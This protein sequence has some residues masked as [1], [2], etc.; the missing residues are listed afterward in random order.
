MLKWK[1]VED[2]LKKLRK[3]LWIEIL[4]ENLINGILI[5]S[6]LG[7]SIV[8]LSHFKSI[9][10]IKQKIFYIFIILL[11][12]MIIKS[13]L[14]N[15]SIEKVAK[16]GD[17]L[18]L[19]QRLIT[20]V[21]LK[22]DK[23]MDGV[24]QIF[25]EDLE[26][27][28]QNF[29]LIKKYKINLH[30][31]KIICSIMIISISFGSYFIPSFSRENALEMEEINKSIKKEIVQIDK[32]KK[33]ITKGLKDEKEKEEI[34]QVF[35]KLKKELKNTYNY[36]KALMEVAK[37]QEK[38]NNITGMK[39]E[40]NLKLGASIFKGTSLQNSELVTALQSGNI[41]DKLFNNNMKISQSDKEKMI[42][43]LNENKDFLNNN[44]IKES[45]QNELMKKETTTKD[46]VKSLKKQNDSFELSSK[47][48]ETKDKLLSKGE[49]KGFENREGNKKSENFSLGGK[50][51]NYKYGEN[52]NI[53]ST[54]N[55]ISG[56]GNS[57]REDNNSVGSSKVG[58]N[59]EVREK[60]NKGTIGKYKEATT[61][62]KSNS[63]SNVNSKV[64]DSGK[65][66]DKSVEEVIGENGSTQTMENRWLDYKKEGM[67]YILKYNI[68]L[69]KE[70]IVIDYFKALKK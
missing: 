60:G 18:G 59:K 57:R 19:K 26:D 39:N 22:E 42:K 45:V 2:V 37:A 8:V 16:A 10:Y 66:F 6:I 50:E 46:L 38:L 48:G 62:K 49:Q 21:E 28:L 61:V 3:K 52:S 41:D 9:V 63:V 36:D 47:L 13:I 44:D 67:D 55:T 43:N 56:N 1:T 65:V 40:K 31:K 20:Y 5:G 25:K 29:D 34:L 24:F 35:K 17:N 30:Y 69:D 23:D 64:N 51:N 32:V 7:F 54:Q 27:E 14:Q 68:P 11:I 4:L 33:D 12:F 58:D 53:K 70:E 15:P